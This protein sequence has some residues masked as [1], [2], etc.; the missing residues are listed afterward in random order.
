MIGGWRIEHPWLWFTTVTI[1]DTFPTDFGNAFDGKVLSRVLDDW[2]TRGLAQARFM[3]PGDV[4]RALLAIAAT[5]AWARRW[6][7]SRRGWPSRKCSSASPTSASTS[8]AWSA[9]SASAACPGCLWWWSRAHA[10]RPETIP[11]TMIEVN[12]LLLPP[13]TF[14]YRL[15]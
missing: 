15:M 12:M 6:P 3:A 1:G 10:A 11:R 14:C 13:S 8:P 4:A 5:S 2:G 9:T 7:G